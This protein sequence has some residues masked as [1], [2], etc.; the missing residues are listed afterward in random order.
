[1]WD[2]QLKSGI[3]ISI[4]ND[5]LDREGEQHG[6][7]KEV[8]RQLRVGVV[9]TEGF[10]EEETPE[11]SFRRWVGGEDGRREPFQMDE[12]YVQTD[13]ELKRLV[14]FEY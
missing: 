9:V 10:L 12:E 14:G 1:M 5:N 3:V 13:L 4:C 2:R 6:S 7:S 8:P 11:M